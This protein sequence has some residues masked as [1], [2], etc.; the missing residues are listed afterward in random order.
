MSCA[1]AERVA[2]YASG[3][4]DDELAAHLPGCSDCRT[5]LA[6]ARTLLRSLAP[7]GRPAEPEG[8]L[9]WADFARGVRATLPVRPRRT[10]LAAP[11]LCAAAA[12]VWIVAGRSLG[13]PTVGTP[14]APSAAVAMAAPAAPNDDVVEELLPFEATDASTHVAELDEK[15]LDSVLARLDPDD[16]GGDADPID[17]IDS[18]DDDQLD[19][20]AATLKM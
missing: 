14:V 5:E 3:E 7:L 16:G 13:A 20:V 10:W 4:P 11:A 17:T 18:L 6:E 15:Q 12:L 19:S 2:A 1:F 9:F 8:E